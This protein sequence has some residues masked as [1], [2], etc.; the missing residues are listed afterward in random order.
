MA[1]QKTAERTVNAVLRSELARQRISGRELARRLDLTPVYVSRRVSGAVDLSSA[2][3]ALFAA[4]LDMPV[5]RFFGE[6][7]K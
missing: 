6:S 7:D 3:L 2:D 4:A 1:N 5:G